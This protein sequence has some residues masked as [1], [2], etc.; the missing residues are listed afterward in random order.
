MRAG[1]REKGRARQASGEHNLTFRSRGSEERRTT[2]RGLGQNARLP[3]F[4]PFIGN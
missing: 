4:K 1:A 2:A 3:V